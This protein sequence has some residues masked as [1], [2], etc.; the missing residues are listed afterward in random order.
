MLSKINNI[1][2]IYMNADNWNSTPPVLVLPQ[3]S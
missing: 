3:S 1:L 2:N